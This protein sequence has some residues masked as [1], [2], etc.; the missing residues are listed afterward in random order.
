[1]S[2]MVC[3]FPYLGTVVCIGDPYFA[4]FVGFVGLSFILH[5]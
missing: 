2:E 1:M 5:F 3:D 4:L